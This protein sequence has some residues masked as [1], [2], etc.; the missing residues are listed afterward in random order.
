MPEP[1]NLEPIEPTLL[2][3][4]LSVPPSESPADTP[5]HPGAHEETIKPQPSVVPNSHPVSN[6]SMTEA[7]MTRAPVSGVGTSATSAVDATQVPPSSRTNVPDKTVGNSLPTAPLS[8]PAATGTQVGRFALK[9]LH[10][11]GGLGEVFT[12]RDTELNREVAVKRIQSRYADDPASRRRFLTEAEITA[13]L[14]HP[15]VVPV[16]GLVADGFGRPCYAMRFIRGET[17]KDEIERYHGTERGTTHG[18]TSPEAHANE[19]KQ[20]ETKGEVQGQ[21][22]SVAFRHLLQRFIAVCQAIA[23]AHTRKVIHRDIKPANVMVGAFGET[24]VVDWGLA[25]ALDDGPD[26]EQLLKA[27]AASGYRRDPEA[28]ELPDH[29]TMAGTAVGTPAYMA[30]EQAS[31]RIDLVGPAADVYSLGATLFAILTG[32]APFSGNTTETLEKVRRGE[33]PTP[34][35]QNPEVPVP[36]DAVCRKAMA[37]RLDDRYATPLDLATDVERWLSDEPVSCHRDPFVA[38]LARWARRHPARVATGVS[39]LLAGVFAAAGIALAVYAGQQETNR[40]LV[41][42]RDQ[43]QKTADE[44]KNVKLEQER[45]QTAL[46]QLESQKKQTDDQRTAAEEARDVARDRYAAAVDAFNLLVSDIQRQLADR[47][48]TQDLRRNLLVEAQKGLQ[49]L[50]NGSG[51]DKIGADRTLVVAHRLMGD[52]H[53]SLGNTQ[54]ARE[55]YLESVSRAVKVLVITRKARGEYLESVSKADKVLVITKQQQ[56]DNDVWEASQELGLS[57]IRLADIQLQAGNTTLAERAC[58][59]ALDLFE[60]ALKQRPNDRGAREY[61]ATALDQ[62]GDIL[63]E[64]G[65]TVEATERCRAALDIRRQLVTEGETDLNQRQL[66]DSLDQYAEVLLR[67]GRTIEARSQ[68]EECLRIR[69]KMSSKLATQPDVTRELAAAHSRLGEVLFDRDEFV[70]CR[71]EFEEARDILK[72]LH[73]EDPRSAGTKAVLAVSHGRL[74]AVAI[75][76]GDLDAALKAATESNRLC[77]EVNRADPDS[78]RAKRDLAASYEWLGDVWLAQGENYFALT[79]YQKSERLLRPIASKDPDSALA[80]RALAHA[81]ERVG[82]GQLA[83]SD[84]AGAIVSLTDSVTLRQEVLEADRDT[85]RPKREV[86]HTSTRAKQELALGL[87]WL[88]DAHRAARQLTFARENVT[89]A[90]TLLRQVVDADKENNNSPA[91]RELA[92]AIGKWGE[93]LA[94]DGKP[95]VALITLSQSLDQL[96]ALAASADKGN[97]HAQAD[98]AAGYERLADLYTRL[99]Q[100]VSAKAAAHS[101]LAIYTTQVAKGSGDTKATRQELAISTIRVADAHA[102]DYQFNTARKHYESA[103]KLVALDSTDPFAATTARLADEKLALLDAVE[104]LANDPA[105]QLVGVPL[106]LRIRALRMALDWRLNGNKPILASS[107]AWQLATTATAPEDRYWGARALALCGDAGTAVKA[108]ELAVAVGFQDVELL[109]GPEWDLCRGGSEFQKV[110]KSMTTDKPLAPGPHRI[111]QNR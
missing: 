95:T 76:C 57:N 47:A 7:D 43:E 49:G 25:K 38:R 68:A 77:Y 52:L 79:W 23:Y 1:R 10:A 69:V 5:A 8:S 82:A 62:F 63:I 73:A 78:T 75:H 66:A 19:G 2:P 18:T 67:A 40:A 53:Q 45:T 28:T 41:R 59:N 29:L 21:P 16:F 107:L 44:M 46:K 64:Q 56:L 100:P 42:V 13:R 6:S 48:G 108:L 17:L 9:G 51:D 84:P 103:R 31:G 105:Q 4:S 80:K 34:I 93:L 104:T 32:R 39:L 88:S 106:A 109:N 87:G 60:P 3:G 99:G 54:K 20:S 36:L 11:R 81:L 33:F 35:E 83:T 30:P 89:Q 12:A 90:V 74:A 70:R 92:L 110:L 55:Q 22:R 15:G 101:A 94:Q 14:D 58:K 65:K 71:A 98:F 24:L 91:R 50:L 86:D 97:V 96:Q 72:K 61:L 37:L 111:P 85:T 27:V 26:P 102:A